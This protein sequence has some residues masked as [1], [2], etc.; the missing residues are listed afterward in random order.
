MDGLKRIS[1]VGWRLLLVGKGSGS[2]FTAS[3]VSSTTC[4]LLK[5]ICACLALLLNLP[6]WTWLCLMNWALSL[7]LEKEL[8]C[9]FSCVLICMNESL[10]S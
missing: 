4:K 7:L 9:S 8:N 10:S 2:A 5:K 6:N 1:P 3:L